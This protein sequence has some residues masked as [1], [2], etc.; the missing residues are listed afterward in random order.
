MQEFG[1]LARAVV[2]LSVLVGRIWWPERKQVREWLDTGRLCRHRF[3]MVLRA[4]ARARDGSGYFSMPCG[5]SMI[6]DIQRQLGP[7]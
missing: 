4:R 6:K 3:R 2:V 5:C 7:G 1:D